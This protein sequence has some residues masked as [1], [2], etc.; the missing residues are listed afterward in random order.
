MTGC[1][2]LAS[3]AE[4]AH[5]MDWI[6]LPWAQIVALLSIL[7]SAG[8]VIRNWY[9]GGS[10]ITV[11]LELMERRWLGAD[12]IG[13]VERWKRSEGMLADPRR[14]LRLD[15][16]KL[17]VR[18][19]GRTAATIMDPGLRLGIPPVPRRNWTAMPI[20]LLKDGETEAR[21]RIETHDA[22]VFY[23]LLEPLVRNA[24][25]EFGDVTI[26][27]RGSITTGTGKTR[28]SPRWRRPVPWTWNILT[29]PRGVDWI[30]KEPLTL[31]DRLWLWSEITSVVYEPSKAIAPQIVG[32]A[33]RIAAAGVDAKA[34]EDELDKLL[35]ILATRE[36]SIA[37]RSWVHSLTD[38]AVR[39]A[40][41]YSQES[42]ETDKSVT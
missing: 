32:E 4:Y 41:I 34:I 26:A 35:A 36:D 25:A 8:L 38:E 13:S 16:V 19:K 14:G 22:K 15:I 20:R 2:S 40:T 9:Y 39:L 30:G 1:T 6:V 23:F 7:V 24:R 10:V 5:V 37:L 33:A 12:V 11:E 3:P 29:L 31:A 21:V 17:T 42:P 28:L 18:N 27:A